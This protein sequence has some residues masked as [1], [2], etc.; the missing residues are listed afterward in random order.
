MDNVRRTTRDQLWDMIN[1][2]QANYERALTIAW[3]AND[4]ELVSR[5]MRSYNK[6]YHAIHTKIEQFEQLAR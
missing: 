2:I 1:A 3:D 5:L 6:K 4:D